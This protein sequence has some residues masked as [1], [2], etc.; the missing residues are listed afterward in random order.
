MNETFLSIL[1]S[2]K[3][4]KRKNINGTKKYSEIYKFSSFEKTK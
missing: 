3:K 4:E 1:T 2:K